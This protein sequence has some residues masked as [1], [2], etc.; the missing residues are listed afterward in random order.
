MSLDLED[1]SFDT[2][3]QGWPLK[4]GTERV[5]KFIIYNLLL[6]G[7]FVLGYRNKNV[8]HTIKHPYNMTIFAMCYVI[9][10]F[11]SQKSNTYKYHLYLIK[12]NIRI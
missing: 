7:Y 9:R 3:K 5:L 6:R 4:L 12:E 10:G 2:K 8:Y 11:R 1:L